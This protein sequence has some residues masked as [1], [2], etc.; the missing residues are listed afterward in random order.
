[1]VHGG[2]LRAFHSPGEEDTGEAS[3]N[4]Q[5][6]RPQLARSQRR[7]CKQA[8]SELQRGGQTSVM[9]VYRFRSRAPFTSVHCNGKVSLRLPRTPELTEVEEIMGMLARS[10]SYW[11]QQELAR[12][13]IKDCTELTCSAAGHPSRKHLLYHHL[14]V[15]E[16]GLIYWMRKELISM[17]EV[18]DGTIRDTGTSSSQGNVTNN[19]VP[20]SFAEEYSL[21]PLNTLQ[22]YSAQSFDR[23]VE[24][25]F[26]QL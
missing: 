20:R 21:V 15:V 24:N 10:A 12:C 23:Q 5:C 4:Q 25:Y 1:M 26:A 6:G 18:N 8:T 2:K 17:D 16:A 7:R 13:W 11:Q 22:K 19:D 3:Q 14:P 9:Q